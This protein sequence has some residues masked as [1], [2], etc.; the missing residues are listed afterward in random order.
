MYRK[1]EY[2][3]AYRKRIIIFLAITGLYLLFSATYTITGFFMTIPFSDNG[4]LYTYCLY[5]I[6][7]NAYS[8]Y[9]YHQNSVEE[10]RKELGDADWKQFYELTL[11]APFNYRKARR[12]IF[13]LSSLAVLINVAL[14]FV[15]WAVW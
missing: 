8:C 14:I 10:E 15:T 1:N 5:A 2:R 6:W 13:L 9:R 4:F 11:F 3:K 7:F 12:H